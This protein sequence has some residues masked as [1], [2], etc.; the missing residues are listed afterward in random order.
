MGTE[1]DMSFDSR[2]QQ[3]MVSARSERAP[4]LN[5][6]DRVMR[7]LPMRSAVAGVAVS[8]SEDYAE[9]IGAGV[10][11][12]VAAGCL[13]MAASWWSQVWMTSWETWHPMVSL[14]Q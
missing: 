2:L 9:W 11:S 3:L 13:W 8:P 5:V 12:L 4:E 10:S 7:A 6:V 14:M 1:N